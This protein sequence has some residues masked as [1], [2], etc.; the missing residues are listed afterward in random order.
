MKKANFILNAALLA[1]IALLLTL[2]NKSPKSELNNSVSV[3][4]TTDPVLKDN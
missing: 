1:V 3:S 2:I 4:K